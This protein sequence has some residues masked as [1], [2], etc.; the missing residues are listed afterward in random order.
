M[1]V[2]DGIDDD[3]EINREE[4]MTSEIVGKAWWRAFRDVKERVDLTLRKKFG[5]RLSLK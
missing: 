1:L 4:T 5:G 3:G 2:Q